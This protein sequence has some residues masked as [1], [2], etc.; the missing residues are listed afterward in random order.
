MDPME[1]SYLAQEYGTPAFVFDEEAFRARMA[2]VSEIFGENVRLCFAV[3]ANPFFIPAAA[4]AGARLEVC[5][6][7]ELDICRELDVDPAAIVFSGVNKTPATVYDAVEFGVGVLTAE[8]KKHVALIE[9]EGA[10]RGK[11]LDVLLRLNAGSQFGMS[12]DDLLEIIANRA[13]FPHV[14]VVGI[15]YFKG[16]QRLKL[17]HQLKEL[18]MLRE[19]FE[20]VERDFGF[21]LERLEYG[22]G[23]GVPQ[24]ADDDFGDTLA[25]AR[26]IAETL[27]DI[28]TRVDLT[29]EMG[30][31]FAAEC[32][33]YLTAVNDV[34]SCEELNYCIV[35]GGINH[36][37]YLGGMMGMKRPVVDHLRY[38]GQE[39]ESEPGSSADWCIAGSLCTTNDVLVRSIELTDLRE[40]DVLAFGNTGAYAVTEGVALLL[41]R[42]LPRV[43]MR[44][45]KGAYALG[46][47]FTETSPLNTLQRGCR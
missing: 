26:E 31:F 32:G 41:S 1:S 39:P 13:Q 11:T 42:T 10:A 38:R 15:H 47:D 29:V 21:T 36:L 34:K 25:P 18:A 30:R 5:S 4:Q 9:A 12:R 46:R 6:P 28:A 16:T 19:L 22:P 20:E 17:K 27:Q 45:A 2:N 37:T 24:F 40:G 7:G 14:N 8:S 23:L 3:K 33:T 43:I 44:E 35:D